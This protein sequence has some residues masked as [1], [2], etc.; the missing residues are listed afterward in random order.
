M[1]EGLTQTYVDGLNRSLDNRE[2]D[3]LYE[4]AAAQKIPVIRKDAAKILYFLTALVQPETVLEIGTGSAYSTLFIIRGL[5]E[6]GHLTSL[7]RDRNRYEAARI[8]L[9][10]EPRVNLV[11][12][13]AFTYFHETTGSFDM[14]FLDAQ[15]RDYIDFL[16]I[17]QHRIKPGGVLI[18][19]NFLFGGKVVEMT[20]EEKE[21]YAGGVE[22][23]KEFNRALSNHPDFEALFLPIGDGICA[24]RK[25]NE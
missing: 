20:E 2:W 3:S 16:P 22:R 23:L 11:F 1:T 7:E 18:A 17:L 4:S 14:V 13:D 9:D 8:L 10:K 21:K 25:K 19:D 24:A 5:P 6:D 12:Q 15:K